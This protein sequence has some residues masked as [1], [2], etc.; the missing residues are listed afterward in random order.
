MDFWFHVVVDFCFNFFDLI[1]V[2][3]WC[4]HKTKSKGFLFFFFFNLSFDLLFVVV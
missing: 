2:M 3:F 4:F 1:L